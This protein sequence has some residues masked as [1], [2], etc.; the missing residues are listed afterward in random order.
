MRRRAFTLIELL[1]VVA[2]IAMLISILMPGLNSARE[3]SRTAACGG[4]LRQLASVAL[5]YAGDHFGMLPLHASEGNV[6][7]FWDKRLVPLFGGTYHAGVFSCPSQLQAHSRTTD[8][9]ARTYRINGLITGYNGSTNK[10][11]LTI[12]NVPVV[13]RTVL[14]HDSYG[15]WRFNTVW[16]W[17]TRGWGDVSVAHEYTEMVTTPW[18]P[19][20]DFGGNNFTFIDGHVEYHACGE[21]YYNGRVDRLILN[22]DTEQ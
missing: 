6:A 20:P 19:R 16:G 7:P 1:V 11:P 22:P 5:A 4:N 12:A 21:G 15:V 14:F 13:N 17:N 18:G 9:Q 3:K 8:Q 2:I 10:P